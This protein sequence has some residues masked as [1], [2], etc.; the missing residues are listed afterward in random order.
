MEKQAPF[1]RRFDAINDAISMAY[2]NLSLKLGFSDGE[3][4]ILYAMYDGEPVTQ[5]EIT[6]RTGMSKQ[7]VSSAVRKLV[8]KGLLEP[9][10]GLR[11][12]P[13][14]LTDRGRK[15]M[16][17]RI[18]LI[19]HVENQ[20]LS[21]WTSEER[22]RFLLLNQRYLDRLRQEISQLSVPEKE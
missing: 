3:S 4:M 9:P 16:R 17:E 1:I 8:Q 6:E 5:K 20:V 19:V 12:E 15:A 2:H 18:S 7:T 10:E 13:L 21:D 11:N 22:Q 14:R